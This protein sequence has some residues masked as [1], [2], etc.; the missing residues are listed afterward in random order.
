MLY[1]GSLHS[2]TEF[3]NL[4]LRDSINRHAELIDY[5]ISLGHEVIAFTEHETISNAI[6]IEEYYSKIKKD[7]PNFKVILGNEIYLCRNDLSADNFIPGEDKYF[8]FILLAKDIIG[9]EQ[10]REL[11]TRAWMRAYN[12]K[13]MWRVPTYYSDLEEIIEKNPGHIVASTACLGGYLG[14]Q[15]LKYRIEKGISLVS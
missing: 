4:R 9:H 12:S 13:N 11:S 10:I 1:P 5:A 2:H 14:T 3:S 7:N 8:H 6:K 15:L